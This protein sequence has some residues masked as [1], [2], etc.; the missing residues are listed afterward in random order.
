MREIAIA[1]GIDLVESGCDDSDAGSFGSQATA[2]GRRI[3]PDRQAADDR[4]AGM[5]EDFRERLCISHPPGR[6]AARA[7]DCDA[8]PGEQLQTAFRIK[9]R[10]RIGR[11]EQCRW[12]DRIGER[13]EAIGRRL[14]PF[15]RSADETCVRTVAPGMCGALPE[16]SDDISR[17]GLAGPAPD[18]RTR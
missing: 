3:D 7:N 4:E 1:R 9:Y 15:Q 17:R 6:G 16:N 13:D 18:R 8:T 2:M 10:W 11:V 5:A 14:Q 12:I